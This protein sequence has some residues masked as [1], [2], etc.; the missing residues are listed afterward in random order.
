MGSF[1]P[2][3]GQIDIR[4]AKGIDGY[5]KRPKQAL[6]AGLN[7]RFAVIQ[8]TF[9]EGCADMYFD[10]HLWRA[11]VG[12]L[13]SSSETFQVEVTLESGAVRPWGKFLQDW[14]SI[15]PEDRDPPPL[16]EMRS[17]GALL[18]SM[19]TEYWTRVG[20]PRLYHDSYTYSLFAPRDMEAEVRVALEAAPGRK[21]WTIHAATTICE[22]RDSFL[23]S[24]LKLVGLPNR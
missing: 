2:S 13:S 9:V 10:E 3:A 21:A 12:V 19:M 20:G 18:L 24:V 6:G 17:G 11:L 1:E 23:R 22:P 7:Q 4:F 15:P 8:D 14:E 5:F 16:V